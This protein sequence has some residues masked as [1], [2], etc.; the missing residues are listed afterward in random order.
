M[1]R[2]VVVTGVGAITP[3]GNG[4]ATLHSAA[5]RGD[6]GIVDGVGRCTAFDG[7]QSLSRRE[8]HRM[9][10][11]AQLAV[12]A[13]D[14][15]IAEAGWNDRLPAPAERV[16]CVIGTAIGGLITLESQLDIMRTE[17]AQFVSPLTVPM[18]MANAAAVHLSMRFGLRGEASALVAACSGG[19]QA[20]VAGVR[21]I[22]SG[23]ADAALVGGAEAAT[24]DFTKAIFA[25]AGALSATG[26]SVPFDRTRD[27]FILGEGAGVLVLEEAELAEARGARILGEILG[28]GV[29]TDGYHLTAPEP[30]GAAAELAVR[31][32]L[33]DGGIDGT[34]LAYINAHG[35]GTHL[36]DIAEV[37]A[38]RAALGDELANIPIS[39]TKSYLG[40]LLGAAG[41]VEAIATLLAL[42]H[43]IAP[44]TCGLTE[45]DEALG[46]LTHVLAA[47]PLTPSAGGCV[48]LSNSMGFGGHNVTIAIRA[49]AA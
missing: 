32:A 42:R 2:R 49:W 36:N 23:E 18:L 17:G 45:P 35:T 41:A 34:Q 30:S 39:S 12:A 11:F 20:I 1:N 44:P 7:S 27:G 6:S 25:S 19:A 29:T 8:L 46:K 43:R 38:L 48:G 28:Y 40:H 3:L 33:A 16:P 9:D 14:E 31:A 24:T 13:A 10:R 5:V 15:A 4:A 26:S 22:R 47:L 37:S 21:A